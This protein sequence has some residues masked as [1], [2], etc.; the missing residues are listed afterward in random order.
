MGGAP[1]PHALNRFRDPVT[2]T[3]ERREIVC[4]IEIAV[5]RSLA[6][7]AARDDS[8]VRSALVARAPVATSGLGH[9]HFHLNFLKRELIVD[10]I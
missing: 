10:Q 6:V 1:T 7:C 3:A 8:R 4:V 2:F 9:D 5:E